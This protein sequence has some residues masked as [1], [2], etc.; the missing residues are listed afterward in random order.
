MTSRSHVDDR[1][2]PTPRRLSAFSI[3]AP[4]ALASHGSAANCDAPEWHVGQTWTYRGYLA[5][6]GPPGNFTT[7]TVLRVDSTSA[8]LR[9]EEAWD[10]FGL[11][12]TETLFS[13]P[14]FTIV[15]SNTTVPNG[16]HYDSV[17]DPPLRLFSFPLA[18]GKTWQSPT[19]LGTHQYR[20]LPRTEVTTPAGAFDA[21]PVEQGNA[22]GIP[23][24]PAWTLAIGTGRA[25]MYYSGDVGQV[26]R[27]E[28]FDSQGEKLGEVAIPSPPGRP[29]SSPVYLALGV[30]VASVAAAAAVGLAVRS[31]RRRSSLPPEAP[32]R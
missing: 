7:T 23:F 10:E 28:A 13:R 2:P 21:F 17:Y 24:L 20:V 11:F 26:V 9:T 15:A 1:A 29:P 3:V 22:P 5:A 14:E 31:R 32:N 16:Q 12:V 6:P 25:L 30:L 19:D 27:Y 8:L 4:L 18:A